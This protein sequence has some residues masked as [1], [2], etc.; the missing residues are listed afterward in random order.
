MPKYQG[1]IEVVTEAVTNNAS[2]LNYASNRLTN[3][4]E[5]VKL[6]ASHA[7]YCGVFDEEPLSKYNDDDELMQIAIKANRANI[8]DA[9]DRIRNDITFALLAVQNR[10]EYYPDEAYESLSPVLRRDRRIVEAVARTWEPVPNCFP[11]KEFADDDTVASLLARHE[12]HF[13]LFGMSRRIK[14]QYYTEDEFERWGDDPWWW[15]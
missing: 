5:L 4:R 14:E 8:A 15:E 2:A 3:D 7:F 9:S 11:P 1:D 6:A 12:D 13:D 10:C